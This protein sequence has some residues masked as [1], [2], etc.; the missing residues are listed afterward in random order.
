MARSN[1]IPCVCKVHKIICENKKYPLHDSDHPSEFCASA[2]VDSRLPLACESHVGCPAAAPQRSC[3]LTPCIERVSCCCCPSTHRRRG[4]QCTVQATQV[5][6]DGRDRESVSF[7]RISCDKYVLEIV[8]VGYGKRIMKCGDQP[9][10]P[11]S[12]DDCVLSMFC[13][14]S[15][16]SASTPPARFS[17]HSTRG[18]G[19][20]IVT[21]ERWESQVL[22]FCNSHH[23]CRFFAVPDGEMPLL[24]FVNP[25]SGGKQVSG[26]CASLCNPEADCCCVGRTSVGSVSE[27]AL[28]NTGIRHDGN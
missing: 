21:C 3:G 28:R 18:A 2:Q 6:Q 22:I 26:P 5:G 11:L 17:Y 1:R 9:S 12:T 7:Q 4:R 15:H 25:K 27:G 16:V 10:P 24:V 13:L 20:S 14:E 23:V 19:I 8:V